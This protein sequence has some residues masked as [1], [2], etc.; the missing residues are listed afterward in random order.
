MFVVLW[1]FKSKV[2]NA[3]QMCSNSQPDLEVTSS[4]T[5]SLK[6]FCRWQH[7]KNEKDD[8]HPNHYDTAILLTR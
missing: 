8:S 2:Y 5:K 3:R 1:L 4:A 6:K 7:K